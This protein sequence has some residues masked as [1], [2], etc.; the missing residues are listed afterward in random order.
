MGQTVEIIIGRAGRVVLYF[1]PLTQCWRYRAACDQ[2]QTNYVHC[3]N[4]LFV[5]NFQKKYF[6]R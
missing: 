3:G 6:R 1:E 5:C 4:A 2:Q